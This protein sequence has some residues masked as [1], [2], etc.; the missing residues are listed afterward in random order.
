MFSVEGVAWGPRRPLPRAAEF[1]WL[2]WA[3]HDKGMA[4]AVPRGRLR[5]AFVHAAG[6]PFGCHPEGSREPSAFFFRLVTP[7]GFC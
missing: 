4:G 3:A 2:R 5:T 6:S 1:L 7:A